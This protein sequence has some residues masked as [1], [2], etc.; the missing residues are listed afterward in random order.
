MVIF[1]EKVSGL[2]TSTV[3]KWPWALQHHVKGE[4]D[5]LR[6]ISSRKDI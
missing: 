1:L 6:C 4:G 3:G 5:L 2:M